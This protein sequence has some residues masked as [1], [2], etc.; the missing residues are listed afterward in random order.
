M[1]AASRLAHLVP[2]WIEHNDAHAEQFEEWAKKARE[3][4]LGAAANEIEAAMRAMKQA[5]EHL[6]DAR[7]KLQRGNGEG[8]GS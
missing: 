7:A 2:H 3:A 6:G 1:D 4:G 5:N 8:F